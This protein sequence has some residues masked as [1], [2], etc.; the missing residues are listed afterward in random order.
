MPPPSKP[1]STSPAQLLMKLAY[2]AMSF[3]QY[4]AHTASR[5]INSIVKQAN[6]TNNAAREMGFCFSNGGEDGEH[7]V[8]VLW[9][10]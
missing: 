6:P 4:L 7:S 8:L 1:I 5:R 9:I 10:T 3:F 2:L